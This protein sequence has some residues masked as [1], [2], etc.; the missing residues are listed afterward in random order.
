MVAQTQIER[1]ERSSL[2][3]CINIM[4]SREIPIW[5]CESKLRVRTVPTLVQLN[6]GN[7]IFTST[8]YEH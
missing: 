3:V 2:I 1:S 4:I 5:N 6:Y 7:L 8:I